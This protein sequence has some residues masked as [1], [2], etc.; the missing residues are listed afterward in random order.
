MDGQAW[1][2]GE[3]EYLLMLYLIPTGISSW[4]YPEDQA[5]IM[6]VAALNNGF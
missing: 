6:K 4:A 1:Y 5:K 3:S 2:T